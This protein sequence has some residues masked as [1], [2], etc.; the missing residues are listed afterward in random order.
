MRIACLHTAE[1]N[2]A[3]FETARR[4]LG[5]GDVMLHHEVRADLLA[6]A[7]QAGGLT[8]EI[9]AR[10]AE[11]L[12]TCCDNADAVLLTCSTLG[13]AIA[14]AAAKAPP[15]LRVD[16][17]LAEDAVRNGGRVVVLCAAATTLAPTR[18]LFEAAA[19]RIGADVEVRL[20]PGAWAAF[21]A[22]DQEG[23]H[24]LIVQAADE[25]TA[26]GASS[27]ALAQ[28]SMAAAAKL[29]QAARPPLTCPAAGLA[30]AVSAARAAREHG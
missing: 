22:G 9:A 13:P 1:S 29:S 30:A 16:A 6:D 19:R 15:I 14:N 21:K 7:E 5:L 12:R 11:A 10:T 25:A 2:V 26:E 27:V 23:Y 8:P 17:A 3:V 24:A 20:I 4:D 18:A 28:A